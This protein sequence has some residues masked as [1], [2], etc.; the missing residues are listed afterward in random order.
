MSKTRARRG[1]CQA[2]GAQ[3]RT[4]PIEFQVRKVDGEL[5]WWEWRLLLLCP[6]CRIG[7]EEVIYAA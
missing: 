7:F 5:A 2:C 1:R 4:V 3:C 6:P